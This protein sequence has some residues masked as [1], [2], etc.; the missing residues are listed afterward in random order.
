MAKKVINSLI[1]MIISCLIFLLIL[2]IV[3]SNTIL[4]KNYVK[5]VLEKNNYYQLTLNRINSEFESYAPQVHIEEEETKLDDICNLKMVTNEVNK[6]IDS[7]YDNK[8]IKVNTKELNE[9]LDNK[10]KKML[11]SHNV[12]ASESELK[13]L[14]EWKSAITGSYKN[15]IIY[16]EKYIKKL[17]KY[18]KFINSMLPTIQKVLIFLIILFT[19]ILVL[20]N[21]KKELIKNIG[22]SFLTTS[23]IAC[24]LKITCQNRFNYIIILSERFSKILIYVLKDVLTK[25]TITGVILGILGLIGIIIGI[26]SDK[27]PK[28]KER[29]DRKI[30][31]KI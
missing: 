21:K 6:V 13:D 19:I 29:N 10:I 17:P 28:K 24:I 12:T 4:S 15:E 18:Y 25:I 31:E 9:L 2:T 26:E 20:Y 5:K 7:I 14:E 27:T 16:T 22:I 23:F 3:S 11:E 1:S 30:K 8:K